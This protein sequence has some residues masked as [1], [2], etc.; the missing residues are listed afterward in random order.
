MIRK[1]WAWGIVEIFKACNNKLV[2]NRWT[3]Q[4]RMNRKMRIT[5]RRTIN[6]IKM[7]L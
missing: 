5:R 3:M 7:M 2:V 4:D 1:K 6:K